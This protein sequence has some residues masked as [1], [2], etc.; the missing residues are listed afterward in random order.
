MN[1][2]VPELAW[3]A[4]WEK[5]AEAHMALL[6]AQA[7]Q[8]PVSLSHFHLWFQWGFVFGS[9]ELFSALCPSLVGQLRELSKGP[10]QW[11]EVLSSKK[12]VRPRGGC[13]AFHTKPPSVLWG[14]QGYC[15]RE[16]GL[17]GAN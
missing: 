2:P 10:G 9:H 11:Q 14:L 5:R 13:G 6:I 15:C 12:R 3:L 4:P 1:M 16:L 7:S 8:D 17:F